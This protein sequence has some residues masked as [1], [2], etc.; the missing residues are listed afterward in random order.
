MFYYFIPIICLISAFPENVTGRELTDCYA[1]NLYPYLKFATKTAY[2]FIYER[3]KL[4]DQ[5][6]PSKYKK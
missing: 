1:N 6:I 3:P 4:R 2:E 5:G